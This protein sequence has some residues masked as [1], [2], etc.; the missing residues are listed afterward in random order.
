MQKSH[1]KWWT[2]EKNWGMQKKKKMLKW[3]NEINVQGRER[4][5]VCVCVFVCLFFK[6][7][8][9]RGLGLDTCEPVSFD[10]WYGDRG[11]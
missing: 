9:N 5:S 4:F 7:T 10:T 11:H 6:N 2:P 3:L 8:F 1:Q